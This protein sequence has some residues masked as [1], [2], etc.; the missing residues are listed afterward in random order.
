[1]YADLWDRYI[2]DRLGGLP[3]RRI[4]PRVVEAFQAD[5]RSLGV[6]DPTLLKV[7]TLLQGVMKRAVL[8][9]RIQ[10][11][12]VA[13]V[14]KPH[15]RRG[16]VVEPPSPYQ[17]EAM[18]IELLLRGKLGDAALVTLLAYAG[19]R[20]GEALGLHWRNVRERTLLIE[21]AASL[22]KLKSTKT[23][24]LRAVRLM[25]P[26]ARDLE[27]WRERTPLA[28]DDDLVF[29]RAD[30]TPWRAGDYKNWRH[31][32]F[33]RAAK[34]AGIPKTCPYDL[35]HAFVSLLLAEGA[36]VL[37][38]A[39]QA[40]H[41]PSLSLDTYG[42][43]IAELDGADRRAAEAVIWEAREAG[44]RYVCD[45]RPADA[46]D[47]VSKNAESP[48][49]AGLS[50]GALLR[51]RTADPLLTIGLTDSARVGRMATKEVDMQGI[52]ARLFPVIHAAPMPVLGPMDAHRVR[53][54]HVG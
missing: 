37:D 12:P 16:R 45:D 6:P 27:H 49:F 43:L 26:L 39:G 1:M 25:A 20:P 11:N 29:P 9:E 40:G 52:R 17:V 13:A 42:H 30:G 18:R 53:T 47:D 22:G 38:V 7:L 31:R 2:L 5:L 51:T 46:V 28:G 10:S 50:R 36:N 48:A 34:A 33:A 14:S 41:A 32:D 3:L 24:R 15:Q 21:Q 4:T 23:R 54:V 8:W 19:L 44:V 35:R